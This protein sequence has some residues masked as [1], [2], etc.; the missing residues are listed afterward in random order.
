MSVRDLLR[1][2]DDGLWCEAGRFHVDP[3]R[4]VERAIVTHA[5]GDHA[6]PGS[7]RYLTAATG[8]ALLV[9]RLPGA[10]VEGLAWG[11]RRVVNGVTVSLHP[12]GHILGSAQV[13]VEHRGEVWVVSG[14]YK[15]DADP[16]CAP[17]EPLRC[18][19]FVTEA[20]FALPVYRWAPAPL[21]VADLA[22]WAL[23]VVASG[24]CAVLFAW[25]LGKAQRLLAELAPRVD[26]PVLVHGA[27]EPHNAVYRA[28]GVG[29]APTELVRDADRRGRHRGVVVLAP[30]GADSPG[31]MR[32]FEG[33]ET[34][35]VSGWMRLR[36]TRRRQAVDRGFALSDH[37]DWD[38]LLRTIT[39][40]GASRVLATHGDS[41][42]L[43]R[44]LGERGLDAASLR[45]RFSAAG[46]GEGEES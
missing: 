42:A 20:T 38:G 19:V 33:A 15:R 5:H 30:P 3:W 34:A 37:A 43:V 29:L 4:P 27:I 22:A 31:W 32:R 40:T 41:A 9:H 18:D 16:T 10:A 26:R 7:A 6:R 36:G 44:L 1:V 28:A 13:R 23:G 17:F 45:T 46:E 2:S 12:A 25:T 39:E 11:E 8:R 21:V 14:D 35:F 24:G